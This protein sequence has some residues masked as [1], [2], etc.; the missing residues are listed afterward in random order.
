MKNGT[1]FLD[2]GH[3]SRIGRNMGRVYLG[4]LEF[5]TCSGHA[6]FNRSRQKMLREYV[7]RASRWVKH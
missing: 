6:F 5:Y 3:V 4:E 7:S 1:Y 2:R